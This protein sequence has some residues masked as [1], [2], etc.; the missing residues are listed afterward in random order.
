MRNLRKFSTTSDYNTW[1]NND[2]PT[3]SVAFI[4]ATDEVK[5][6]EYVEPEPEVQVIALESLSI[7]GAS[8]WSGQVTSDS[9]RTFTVA[10]NP[11]DTTQTNVT[12]STNYGWPNAWDIKIE[13]LNATQAKVYGNPSMDGTKI[14][15]TVTSEDN[16]TISASKTIT[17]SER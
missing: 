3:P 7:S 1:S 15:I 14:I 17:Y 13:K 8:S 2:K 10:F 9:L 4:E 16:P 12:W 6:H 11:S 5:Y